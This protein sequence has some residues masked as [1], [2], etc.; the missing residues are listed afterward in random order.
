MCW[1]THVLPLKAM[2]WMLRALDGYSKLLGGEGRCSS[3]KGVYW[4][5]GEQEQTGNSVTPH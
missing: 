4:S 2:L 1:Q 5:A 3:S